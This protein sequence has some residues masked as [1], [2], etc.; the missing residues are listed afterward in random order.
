MNLLITHDSNRILIDSNIN[1]NISKLPSFT[2]YKMNY[3]NI[4]LFT[5]NKKIK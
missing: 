5:L 4:E 1:C 2:E 3:E